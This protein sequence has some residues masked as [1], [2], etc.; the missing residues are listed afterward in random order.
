VKVKL[1]VPMSGLRG[2][3]SDWP[4][5]GTEM[6]VDD[7]EGAHLCQAGIVEPV[8]EERTERAVA[9]EPEKRATTAATKPATKSK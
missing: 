4:P 1:K 8:V 3:G 9:R 2:D 7:E 5:V 6:D